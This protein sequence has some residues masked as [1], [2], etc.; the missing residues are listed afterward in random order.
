MPGLRAPLRGEQRCGAEP[1]VTP[2]RS[3]FPGELF[4]QAP[5]EQFPGI[6]VEGVTDSSRYFVIRIEDGNGASHTPGDPQS[7]RCSCS[8]RILA[9]RGR[10]FPAWAGQREEL[11]PS[12]GSD[13]C[14]K[15]KHLGLA[16]QSGQEDAGASPCCRLIKKLFVLKL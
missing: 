5:V 6:A 1:R 16:A 15:Q 4:A 9:F 3:C 11:P 8:G 13:L 14:Q 2:P 10:M 12:H 7:P